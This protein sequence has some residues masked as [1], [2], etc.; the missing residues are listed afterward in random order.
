MLWLLSL[1]SQLELRYGPRRLAVLVVLIAAVSNFCQYCFSTVE[2]RGL[3]PV[4]TQSSPYFGGMSGVVFGLFGFV[5]MKA[6]YEPGSGLYVSPANIFLMIVWLILCMT[7][8]VGPI[9]NTAH[10][11][12]LAVGM[13]AGYASAWW[14]DFGGAGAGPEPGPAEPEE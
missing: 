10:L 14:N 2:L 11:V 1:G 7:G 5:W 8:K 13:L 6:V 4:V 3:V 12:G 9:A